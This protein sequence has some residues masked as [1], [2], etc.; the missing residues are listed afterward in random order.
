MAPVGPVQ[1]LRTWLTAFD[2]HFHRLHGG[3]FL[4]VSPPDRGYNCIAWAAGDN[5]QW[6]QPTGLGG[7][8]WPAGVPLEMTSRAY[9]AAYEAQGYDV[10][11]SGLLE[12]GYEKVA[13]FAKDGIPTHA[14]RQLPN[15]QWTSKLGEYI[16]IVHTSA[17]NVG[18]G[19]YGEVVAFL[20]RA[21]A[22]SVHRA[23]EPR[24]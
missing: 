1:E 4:R 5:S 19:L 3:N 21:V 13:I 12:E 8:Y 20:R 7:H 15:G 24:G 17:E 22:T 9:Q 6:W 11:S 10:C 2:D 18:G 23:V 14:A 16:D